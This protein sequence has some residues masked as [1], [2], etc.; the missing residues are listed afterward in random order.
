MNKEVSVK[1]VQA[2]AEELFRSGGLYCSEAIVAAIRSNID[3]DMPSELVKAASGFPVGVGRSKCM[4]GAVSGAVM[5]IGYFFGR[6]EPTNPQDPDSAKC[7]DLANEVQKAF[8]DSH[9]V[10]CCSVH[11]KGMDLAAGEN[12]S[13]CIAFTGEMAGVAAG[14]IVRELGLV[15]LD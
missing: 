6:S 10:L 4:C 5:A 8:R 1:K 3:P 9:R 14:V 2:D 13:Q 15:S 7:L 12:K 11:T